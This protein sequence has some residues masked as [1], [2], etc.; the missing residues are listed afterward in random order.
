MK[1]KVIM[2]YVLDN[3]F[4]IRDLNIFLSKCHYL[5]IQNY[6]KK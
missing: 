2:K 1:S 6:D 3:G 5:K 4:Y